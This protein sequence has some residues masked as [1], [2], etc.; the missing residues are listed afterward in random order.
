MGQAPAGAFLEAGH[1]T[2]V[3][4]RTPFK[5]DQH[6]DRGARLAVDT[7]RARHRYR[8]R[9]GPWLGVPVR[10]GRPGHDVKRPERLAPRHCPTQDG[11]C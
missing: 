1:P 6:V 10:R 9:C 3:W 7:R 5:A 2:T 4:N 11:P 8:P